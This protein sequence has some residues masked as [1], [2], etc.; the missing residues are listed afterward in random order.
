[1]ASTKVDLCLFQLIVFSLVK[2]RVSTCGFP[3]VPPFRNCTFRV[4][5]LS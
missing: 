4:F 5:C 1:M 2:V 3:A